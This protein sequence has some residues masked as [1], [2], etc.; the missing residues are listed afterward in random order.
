MKSQI[1]IYL[2][3]S[4]PN[5]LFADDAPE[6][7]EATIEFFENFI[8]TNV[9]DCLISEYVL[10]EIDATKNNEKKELL[11]DVINKYPVRILEIDNKKIEILELANKYIESGVIPEKKLLDALHVAVCTVYGINILVSWNF[12]H[13]ANI[14]KEYR[15]KSVNYQNLYFNDLRII[16]PLE[17][18]NYES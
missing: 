2:D 15:I 16:T 14:N 13:L 11:Y 5:F 18:I 4:V 8:L 1:K 17:L 3:T 12:K 10:T 6:K 9:Y 7:K